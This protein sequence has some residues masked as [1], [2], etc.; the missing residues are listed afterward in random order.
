MKLTFHGAAKEVTGSCYLL[1]TEDSRI[2]V[3]SGMFQGPRR[4]ERL[5]RIPKEIRPLDIDAVVLTHGHLDHCG[6]LPMLYRSGYRG[7]IYATQG[8]IEIATLIMHDA[9]HI[10][11]SDTRKENR[12]R[13]RSGRPPV[14]PLFDDKD[15]V[16][17]IKQFEPV[18]YK[19][20]TKITNDIKA[21][22]VEAG[23]ILGSASIELFVNE[24][25]DRKK[26]VFSGDIGQYN[27][28]LMRDPATILEADT[29]IMEST[30]GDRDHRPLDK[31]LEEFKD[32]LTDTAHNGGK[33]LIPTFAIGRTQQILYYLASMFNK[34]EV[35]SMSV[36]LDS[37]MG[38]AATNIYARHEE[39]MDEHAK[40]IIDDGEIKKGKFKFRACQ[41]VE[42][43]QSLNDVPGPCVIM[44]GAGMCNA[45]RILH[46]FKHNL[47][48]SDTK[49]IMVGYQAKGSLGRLLLDGAQRVKIFRESIQVN[50]T[51][52]SIGGFSAHAGQTDLLKW[53]KP[54][55]NN[56]TRVILTHGE[57]HQISELAYKIEKT[58]NI[59]CHTPS[60]GEHM[61][62]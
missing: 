33:I 45:G 53:L 30:Y 26:L 13:M 38:I 39:I 21:R 47:W 22:F 35:P 58:Y 1:S 55:A 24:N 14:K 52:C 46:H 10:Q 32:V 17:V 29:V 28:P 9:A 62:V 6:R 11:E 44:A 16:Q 60:L 48:K 59:K 42:E 34:G 27:V 3:D 7:P 41:S 20:T 57:A 8:T 15:V 4:L 54:M 31:T 5:N 49:V 40:V 43:S 56:N 25:G 2:L 23:H 50:A 51:I 36:Y 19:Q 37:P 12:R 18:E 61:E